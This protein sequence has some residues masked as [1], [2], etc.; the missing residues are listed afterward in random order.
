MDKLL[1]FN[2]GLM[3]FLEICALVSL[4]YWAFTV[5]NLLYYPMCLVSEHLYSAKFVMVCKSTIYR[6]FFIVYKR[7]EPSLLKFKNRLICE[8]KQ[9]LNFD[10]LKIIRNTPPLIASFDASFFWKKTLFCLN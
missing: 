10:S 5:I 8:I 9:F 7:H 1:I 4:A 6:Q 3:F 2:K